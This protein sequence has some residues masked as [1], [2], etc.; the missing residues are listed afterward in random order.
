MPNDQRTKQLQR[1]AAGC[2]EPDVVRKIQPSPCASAAPARL[3]ESAQFKRQ[4][5]RP[6]TRC[7]WGHARARYLFQPGLLLHLGLDRNRKD[8]RIPVSIGINSSSGAGC[9]Q[10][11]SCLSLEA[12]KKAKLTHLPELA[13]FASEEVSLSPQC[14]WTSDSNEFI[15]QDKT[16]VISISLKSDSLYREAAK[17]DVGK[18][19]A[20][21]RD[22]ERGREREK[23]ECEEEGGQVLSL[24][25]RVLPTPYWRFTLVRACM[26]M[27][28]W[29]FSSKWK[30]RELR[31]LDQPD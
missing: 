5:T 13:K 24:S 15:D 27:L 29:T 6:P 31:A 25:V 18:E 30:C 7:R 14:E 22:R 17:V 10:S 9:S 12:I 28:V 2:H 11:Y 21:E 1:H 8:P 20:R 3:A 23:S 26:C 4:L 16:K 19:R